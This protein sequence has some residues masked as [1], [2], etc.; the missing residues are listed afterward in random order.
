[1]AFP[2]KTGGLQSSK[3]LTLTGLLLKQGKVTF[4]DNFCDQPYD[5][6]VS[7]HVH[8]HKVFFKKKIAF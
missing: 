2:K 6:L 5:S 4:L 3:H 8:Q 7:L 1:M